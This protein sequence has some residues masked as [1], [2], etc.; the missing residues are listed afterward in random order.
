[1]TQIAPTSNLPVNAQLTQPRMSQSHKDALDNNKP[2]PFDKTFWL[3]AGGIGIGTGSTV[4]LLADTFIQPSDTA[5]HA[6]KFT[7]NPWVTL[8]VASSLAALG[9]L[10]GFFASKKQEEREK[11]T[12]SLLLVQA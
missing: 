4:G 11:A 3:T 9:G 10:T 2:S 1:M 7:K 12:A 8:G 5:E 6:A